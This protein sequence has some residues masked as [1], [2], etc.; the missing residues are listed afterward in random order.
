MKRMLA[1]TVVC[2]AATQA[3]GTWD[4][5]AGR[6]GTLF[7]GANDAPALNIRN[8]SNLEITFG[9][10]GFSGEN[11]VA[12][13][14]RFFLAD[15]AGT[16][17]RTADVSVGVTAP[18]TL[19][20]IHVVQWNLAPGSQYYIGAIAQSANV[21]Y[22]YRTG[23][24]ATTMD[25]MTGGFNNGNFS[26]YAAPTFGGNGDLEMCWHLNRQLPEPASLF[27]IGGGITSFI[28]RRRTR[29]GE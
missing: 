4:N 23:G 19:I 28:A 21:N 10:V 29:R 26:N 18:H 3:C 16:V 9:E 17:L 7:R 15:S 25:G 1:L 6:T 11:T 27:V 2:A 22:D 14:F 20:W 13:N 24:S 12:Q 8:V 5:I